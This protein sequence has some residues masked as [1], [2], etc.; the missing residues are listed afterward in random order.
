MHCVTGTEL[1]SILALQYMC[2]HALLV[3]NIVSKIMY[4]L[5]L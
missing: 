5:T 2:L 1:F 4:G 3:A